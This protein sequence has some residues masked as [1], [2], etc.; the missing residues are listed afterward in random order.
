[1]DRQSHFKMPERNNRLPSMACIFVVNGFDECIK[2]ITTSR[3]ST[4]DG[5]A[6]FLRQLIIQA[7]RYRHLVGQGMRRRI[8]S[9]NTKSHDKIP[10]TTSIPSLTASLTKICTI[11]QVCSE[12]RLYWVA[13]GRN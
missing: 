2:M 7:R 4:P 8:F 11:N 1:M 10:T 6:K 3:I 9:I 12:K 13:S 5:G